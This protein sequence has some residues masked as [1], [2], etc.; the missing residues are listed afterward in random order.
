MSGLGKWGLALQAL[1]IL[2]NTDI[3]FANSSGYIEKEPP[4]PFN[5]SFEVARES[6]SA[7]VRLLRSHSGEF[8]DLAFPS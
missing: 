8:M 2:I 7:L 3:S 1:T 5:N 4:S 6:D